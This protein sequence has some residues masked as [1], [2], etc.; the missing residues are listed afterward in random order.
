VTEPRLIVYDLASVDGRLTISPDTLLMVGDDRWNAVAGGCHDPYPWLIKTFGPQAFLEGSGSFVREGDRSQAAVAGPHGDTASAEA[1]D[2]AQLPGDDAGELLEDFLPEAVVRNPERR[3]WFVAVDGRGRV[4]WTVKEWPDE[5]FR[6][7][8]LLVLAHHTTPRGYLA[9]LR[10]ERIPYLL[11]GQRRVDLAGALRKLAGLLG[12]TTVVSTAGGKLNGALMR[13][14]LVDEVL[15]E[16]FP[17]VIGGT[18][19]PSLFDAPDLG[20]DEWPQ[21]LTLVDVER[22]PEGHVRLRYSVARV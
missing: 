7:W 17:A 3:G 12:V 19:T 21:R 15:V 1:S 10:E 11:A 20:P 4:H 22:L 5:A 9:F 18:E 16:V 8:H 13:A 14:G 6:G 2:P